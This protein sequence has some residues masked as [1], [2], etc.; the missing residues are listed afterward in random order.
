ME[1]ALDPNFAAGHG[2][3]GVAL[4]YAGRPAEAL[5][6]IALAMRL[7]PH[8]PAHVL[9]F[10]AQANF[11]LENYEAA[12]QELLERIAR[13][14]GT[15]ASRMLLDRATVISGARTRRGLHGGNL[16]K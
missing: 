15:D 11:S 6:P 5:E 10:L 4:M 3:T 2:A 1:I 8:Y 14:P 16:S 13:T 7:D 12:A 9:H